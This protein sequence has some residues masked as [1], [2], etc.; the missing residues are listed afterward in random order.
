MR[1]AVFDAFGISLTIEPMCLGFSAMVTAASGGPSDGDIQA[2]TA[3]IPDMRYVDEFGRRGGGGSFRRPSGCA[4]PA[5]TTF[6]EVCQSHT[7]AVSRFGI[8]SLLPDTVR[9]VS[10]PGSPLY[11]TPLAASTTRW[12]SPGCRS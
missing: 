9:L 5:P 7:I 3:I 10:G 8:H 12:P 6:M 1:G 4:A 11:V 2:V